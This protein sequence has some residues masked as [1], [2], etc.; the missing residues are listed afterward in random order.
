MDKKIIV[1]VIV[2]LSTI[3]ISGCISTPLSNVNEKIDDLNQQIETGDNNFNEAVNHINEKNYQSA[4]DSNQKAALGYSKCITFL[5]N[6]SEDKNQLNE[7]IYIE[8]LNLVKQEVEC[9][10][11]ATVYLDKAINAYSTS[12]N[13]TGN[14]YSTTANNLMSDAIELQKERNNIVNNNPD[15]FKIEHK[16]F[17]FNYI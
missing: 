2:L 9:K 13:S 17:P 3:A 14:S 7:S 15:K 8:Y 1:I 10:H 4:S 5:D 12:S 6:I 11:N 16:Q